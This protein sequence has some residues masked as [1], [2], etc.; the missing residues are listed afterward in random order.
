MRKKKLIANITTILILDGLDL[1]E[2]QS[3]TFGNFISN[4]KQNGRITLN[5][6]ELCAS[7]WDRPL[8]EII[9]FEYFDL[10]LK[11]YSRVPEKNKIVKFSFVFNG[12]GKLNPIKHQWDFIS[13]Y[14]MSHL[15]L[16]FQWLQMLVVSKN[17]QISKSN[18]WC[19]FWG[20]GPLWKR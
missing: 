10:W 8:W 14:W 3:C 19:H 12:R 1:C 4:E 7:S 2:G 20:E 5:W 13:Q 16:K 11:F 18:W 9:L 6:I 15:S 17:L